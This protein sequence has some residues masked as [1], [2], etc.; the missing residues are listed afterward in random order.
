MV[1]ILYEVLIICEK[2]LVIHFSHWTSYHPLSRRSKNLT[3]FFL[4]V[5]AHVDYAFCFYIFPLLY[6]E[7][8]SY[9]LGI[10]SEWAS[11][12]ADFYIEILKKKWKTKSLL[13]LLKIKYKWKLKRF[14][15]NCL[16]ESG[17]YIRVVLSCISSEE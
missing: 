15:V 3:E 14:T 6:E 7:L 1:I 5:L 4:S 13:M 12:N 10:L 17:N 8:L 11:Q 16:N 2:K 9:I